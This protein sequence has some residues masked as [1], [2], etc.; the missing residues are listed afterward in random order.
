MEGLLEIK[1]FSAFFLGVN[2]SICFQM[3]FRGH[4]RVQAYFF[5]L[6]PHLF[7][8]DIT[9]IEIYFLVN[10]NTNTLTLFYTFMVCFQQ[11]YSL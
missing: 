3:I 7:L 4:G 10:I 9:L 11:H 2:L 6:F 8:V 1:S 5:S